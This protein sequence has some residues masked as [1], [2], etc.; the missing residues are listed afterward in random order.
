MNNASSGVVRWKGGFSERTVHRFGGMRVM[1]REGS[2]SAY[3]G[4]L[5]RSVKASSGAALRE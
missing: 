3:M 4:K 5:E 2:K 1:H